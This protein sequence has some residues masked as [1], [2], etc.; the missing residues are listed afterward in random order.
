M[1]EELKKWAVTA[2]GALDEILGQED[3]LLDCCGAD[4]RETFEQAIMHLYQEEGLI[5]QLME[6]RLNAN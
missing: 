4:N 1:S 3:E 2:Y 5:R 6:V